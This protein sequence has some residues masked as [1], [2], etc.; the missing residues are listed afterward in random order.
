MKELIVCGL[1]GEADSCETKRL[2]FRTALLKLPLHNPFS[3]SPS[4]P[5]DSHTVLNRMPRIPS[6]GGGFLR[7]SSLSSS[8]SRPCG[9][10]RNTF[11][12]RNLYLFSVPIVSLLSENVNRIPRTA[13]CKTRPGLP[14]G[15]LSPL[16]REMHSFSRWE[17]Q[18]TKAFSPSGQLF[19]VR[20]SSISS[21]FSPI[22]D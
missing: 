20:I 16:Y 21:S 5:D 17:I 11:K 9:I 1:T 6:A 19:P 10:R 14:V 12:S 18:S 4:G 8:V 7:R 3:S 22:R 2:S 15:D 13:D